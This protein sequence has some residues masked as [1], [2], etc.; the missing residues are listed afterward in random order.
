MKEIWKEIRKGADFQKIGQTFGID[1]LIARIVRNRDMMSEE[2]IR[3]YLYGDTSDFLSPWGL[4]DMQKAVDIIEQK[5]ALGKKI[6]VIGDYDI[7]GVMSTYILLKGLR[8]I[9]AKVD[10]YIPDRVADGYGL[11][12]KLVLCAAEDQIDTIVTCDNGIAAFQEIHLAKEKGMTVIVTDHHNVPFEIDGS[13]GNE[14]RKYRIPEA[15]AVI[16]PKQESCEYKNKSLCG[17]AVA[18]KLVLALY[19]R[20]RIPDQEAED[21]IELAA[22]AT[23]GDI[24]DL[25]GENRTIVR[26]GLKRIPHTTNKG[27]R[28]LMQVTNKMDGKITAYDIG[29]ILG[30]CINAGGRLDTALR[31][32]RLLDADSMHEAQRL[33]GDLKALNDS[34]KAMTNLQENA[35]VKEVENS[36][37]QMD[38]VLVLYLPDCHESLAGLVASRIRERYYKPTIVLTRGGEMIKGSARS[39][40]EYSI[41]DELTKCSS[42]LSKFGGHPMAA[43]MSLPEENVEP[44]RRML[45][46]Y[47]SLSCEEMVPTVLIDAQLPMAYNTLER[48]R[49]MELL[50]PYGKGNRRPLFFAGNMRICRCD[51]SQRN[52][53]VVNVILESEDGN[54]FRLF[55]Y[56]DSEELLQIER[57]QRRISVVYYPEINHYMGRESLQLRLRSFR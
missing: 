12:E 44:L 23:V 40:E 30:P 16:N 31:A 22:F 29:F 28:A 24:V 45:N 49:Q 56:G 6:R 50:E 54:Q 48:T 57:E 39:I 20:F 32:L 5:V 25:V 47:C 27:L 43:G 4:K 8:R 34:R 41:I 19:E 9:G 55:Y 2:E 52:E 53:K 17:A 37:L 35:A 46:D 36:S 1:P 26:E 11:H 15:D 3:E 38:K 18:W 51:V 21:F 33:A 42:L 14:K 13:D 10:T 7:D